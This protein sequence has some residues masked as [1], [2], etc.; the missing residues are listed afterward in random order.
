M[1]ALL[2]AAR[3]LRSVHGNEIQEAITRAQSHLDHRDW[4]DPNQISMLK[5]A[6][7]ALK[8]E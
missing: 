3:T 7:Q 1:R 5:Y 4:K 8:E 6:E 2:N